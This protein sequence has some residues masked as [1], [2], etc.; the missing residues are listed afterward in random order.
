V[1]GEE[2]GDESHAGLQHK[3]RGKGRHLL[4]R[5]EVA[6][7]HP[8]F[9]L[10]FGAALVTSWR[11]RHVQRPP[12]IVNSSCRT[13]LCRLPCA[14]CLLPCGSYDVASTIFHIL[15]MA[16]APHAQAFLIT[17]FFR[18]FFVF[19][20]PSSPPFFVC[21]WNRV[22]SREKFSASCVG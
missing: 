4:R 18:R 15:P 10:F 17:A 5:G 21:V 6:Y 1:K 14:S 7:S 16:T 13:A 12:S 22:L 9:A 20:L 2:G 11:R 8:F 19:F 3:V